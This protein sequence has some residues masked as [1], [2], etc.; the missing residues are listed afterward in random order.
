MSYKYGICLYSRRVL[1]HYS[2]LVALSASRR[3]NVNIRENAIAECHL[4]MFFLPILNFNKRKKFRFTDLSRLL[5]QPDPNNPNNI[6]NN[7]Q[8]FFYYPSHSL[9]L[10]IP[11]S[12]CPCYLLEECKHF[13]HDHYSSYKRTSGLTFV[14]TR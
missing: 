3:R 1:T 11:S 13:I 9:A 6:Y 5:C 2:S 12:L 7:R 8:V 4:G 14:V 10:Q